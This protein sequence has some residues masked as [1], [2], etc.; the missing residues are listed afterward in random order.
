[1]VLRLSVFKASGRL[2]DSCTWVSNHAILD[3]L[4]CFKPS[5]AWSS[6][7][8]QGFWSLGLAYIPKPGVSGVPAGGGQA[9][10]GG[11]LAAFGVKR[12][13]A[14]FWLICLPYNGLNKLVPCF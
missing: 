3:L 5:S 4:R 14:A 7:S 12:S 1:M 10:A 11:P 9:D 6:P 8:L 2:F 13:A